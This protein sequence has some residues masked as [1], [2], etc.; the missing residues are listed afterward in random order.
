MGLLL[1]TL[2]ARWFGGK[3]RR[4]LLLGL[5]NAGKTTLLNRIHKPDSISTAT[6]PTVGFNMQH[7][8]VDN[9]HI[10]MWDLGGQTSIRRYWRLYVKNT[11]AI[12]YVVDSTDRDRF[13]LARTELLGVLEEEELGGVMVLVMANKQ[14]IPGAT[15]AG[16]LSNALGLTRLRDRPWHICAASAKTGEGVT[17]GLKWIVDQLR[18]TK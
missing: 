18:A 4:L 17:D 11:D 5:D 15:P 12:I 10:A 16:D 1:S 2:W 9:V 7:C 13:E 6:I 14:D 3:E 8:V